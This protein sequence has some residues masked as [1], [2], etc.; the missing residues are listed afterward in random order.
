[1]IVVVLLVAPLIV[2]L[3]LRQKVY[4]VK[5]EIILVEDLGHRLARIT[6]ADGRCFV[7]HRYH[8]TYRNVTAGAWVKLEVRKDSE[9]VIDVVHAIFGGHRTAT[10]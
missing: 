7:S 5:T 8:R 1:M 9:D 2:L 10:S 4:W 6:T 3:C